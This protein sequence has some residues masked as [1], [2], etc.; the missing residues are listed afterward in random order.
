MYFI[1]C[2]LIFVNG[3]KTTQEEVDAEIGLLI[4]SIGG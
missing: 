4:E 3:V 2:I 1:F